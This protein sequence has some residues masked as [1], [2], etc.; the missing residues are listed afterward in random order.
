MCLEHGLIANAIAFAFDKMES[1]TRARAKLILHFNG[2]TGV[3]YLNSTEI[4]AFL[5]SQSRQEK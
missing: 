4:P 3:I 5:R 1:A 2:C